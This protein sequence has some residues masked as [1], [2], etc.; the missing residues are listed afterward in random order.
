VARAR[1]WEVGL[2]LAVV[3]ER[4]ETVPVWELVWEPELQG[5]LHWHCK[6]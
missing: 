5:N 3:L 1:V 4:Q 6:S 2:E